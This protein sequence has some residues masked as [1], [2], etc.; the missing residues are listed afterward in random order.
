MVF[1][2]SLFGGKVKAQQ[3]PMYSQ[4]MFNLLNVN[5]A[6]AG[7][8]MV[9][10]ITALYRQQWVGINKAPRTGTIS[11]DR[12][13]DGSNM[14]YGMQLYNDRLGIENTTGFQ[15]FY[16]YGIPFENSTLS[17]GVSGGILNYRAA[18]T[19]SELYDP[20]DPLFQEDVNGWL[21]TAGF[22]ILYYGDNWYLSLSVPAL[23]KTKIDNPLYKG[24][25]GLGADNHYFFSG[26]YVFPMTETFKLK[27]SFMVQAVR[28]A[29]LSYDLNVN[30]WFDDVLSAGLSYRINDAIVG[31]VE[32]QVTPQIRI[33]YAYDYTISK[34]SSYNHGT[35]E[36]MLRYE[37]SKTQGERIYSPRYY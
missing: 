37:F 21:P 13:A 23:L 8:R 6:Y 32:L 4:Y 19:E 11:W 16:S 28:G 7:T 24:I 30:G 26:G 10:N 34:L 17:F 2:L 9:D 18:L 20:N 22:G 1:I 25:T 33:G 12:R 27:P 35:H 31:M 3:E 5:P 29:S 15:A 14:G 36:L